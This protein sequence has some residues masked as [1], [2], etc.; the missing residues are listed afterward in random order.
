MHWWAQVWRTLE[1]TCGR[2]QKNCF[3]I[4]PHCW[5]FVFVTQM[6]QCWVRVLLTVRKMSKS[7]FILSAQPGLYPC[8]LV[9]ERVNPFNGLDLGRTRDNFSVNCTT[10]VANS[11]AKGGAQCPTHTHSA[12]LQTRQAACAIFFFLLKLVSTYM[13]SGW[14]WK[15][16]GWNKAL[17]CSHTSPW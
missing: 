15:H 6:R 8:W 16:C 7:S 17:A 2:W 1:K 14:K 5:V 4:Y 11:K 13:S 12:N 3:I 10:R 9:S